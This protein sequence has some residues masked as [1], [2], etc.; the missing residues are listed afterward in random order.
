MQFFTI[1]AFLA[2]TA[3]AA[4]I[5]VKGKTEVVTV[6]EGIFRRDSSENLKGISFTM[7][8]EASDVPIQCSVSDPIESKLYP[9]DL[10][11]Y[12]FGLVDKVSYARFKLTVYHQTSSL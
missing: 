1:A 11:E 8:S 12:T 4:V 2:A 7:K 9:C 6:Q 3:T 5:P 10:P